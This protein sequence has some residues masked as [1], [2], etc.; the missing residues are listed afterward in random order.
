MIPSCHELF[1]V[2]CFEHQIKNTD[3]DF[4]K[5]L[6]REINDR[7]V[8]QKP[9]DSGSP[10]D[11][12]KI[13]GPKIGQVAEGLIDSFAKHNTTRDAQ[14][15]FI[16]ILSDASPLMSCFVKQQ[17]EAAKNAGRRVQHC[18][19]LYIDDDYRDMPIDVCVNNCMIFQG[20]H[21][22]ANGTVVD[23]ATLIRCVFCST[24]RWTHC[25]HAACKDKAYD[26]CNP[27]GPKQLHGNAMKTCGVP[28]GPRTTSHSILNRFSLNNVFYRSMT[29]RFT[30]MFTLSCTKE[31]KGFMSY[32]RERR[33]IPDKIIDIC[34]GAMNVKHYAEMKAKFKTFRKGFEK[35]NKKRVYQCSI[36][37]SI[38]YDGK[39]NFQRSN[40]SMWPVVISVL[41]CNPSDR[42]TI[43]QGL[44]L[45]LLHNI[46]INSNAETSVMQ[47][48]GE[49]MKALEEGFMFTI[50]GS[51]E[52]THTHVFLQ[53]RCV[54]AHLDTKGLE[55]F[56]MVQGSGSKHGCC[57]CNLCKGRYEYALKKMVY[58]N[59]RRI[60]SHNH[61]IRFLGES[62]F[63]SVVEE[64][65]YYSPNKVIAKRLHE[66][67]KKKVTAEVKLDTSVK[68]SDD[69][70]PLPNPVFRE[71]PV[72]ANGKQVKLDWYNNAFPYELFMACLRFAYIDRRPQLEYKHVAHPTY[73]RCGD[74]SERLR[75]AHE[76]Q[77]RAE[78]KPKPKK[79]KTFPCAGIHGV[80]GV[81][82]PGL[83]A[84]TYECLTFDEMHALMNACKYFFDAWKGERCVKDN[85]RQLSVVTKKHPEM[86]HKG[87]HYHQPFNAR[88]SEQ[89]VMDAVVNSLL[90]NT[91]YK[92][93]FGFK[94]P[95][96]LTGHLISHQKMVFLTVYAPYVLRFA[97]SMHPAYMHFAAR[98][99]SDVNR[100]FD[101]VVDIH[102][103]KTSIIQSIYETRCIQEGIF[104]VSEAVYI[105][106]ELLC[107][108]NHI[109][110]Y[111]HVRGLSTYF[112][113]RAIGSIGR[114]VNKGGMH[115][116]KTTNAK[117]TRKENAVNNMD[118]GN[119]DMFDNRGKYSDFV[120][121][122]LGVGKKTECEWHTNDISALFDNLV[123][124]L[125][126]QESESDCFRNSAVY[127]LYKAF[128]R[129]KSKF[130]F[131][132]NFHSWMKT[133]ARVLT[134]IKTLPE[135]SVATTDKTEFNK[136]LVDLIRA[137][138]I[139]LTSQ[140]M[141]AGK[142]HL[143]DF[144]Q[145]KDAIINFSPPLHY[146]AIVKG[147][148]LSARGEEYAESGEWYYG[149]ESN[150]SVVRN[151]LNKLKKFW[152]KP[153]QY[154]CFVRVSDW[155]T[156]ASAPKAT[157]ANI[158][159]IANKSSSAAVSAAA[160]AAMH[161]ERMDHAATE[162]S[163]SEN[164]LIQTAN[165]AKLELE[166]A[167]TNLTAARAHVNALKISKTN[168][169]AGAVFNDAK[170]AL[171]GA[172]SNLREKTVTV[173]TTASAV[174]DATIV[175]KESADAAVAALV[176]LKTAEKIVL[177]ANKVVQTA[178]AAANKAKKSNKKRSYYEED[179]DDTEECQQQ[180]VLRFNR[181]KECISVT[182]F[183][184]ANAFFRIKVGDPSIDGLAFANIT[185]RKAEISDKTYHHF[186]SAE[187]S[188]IYCKQKFVCLNYVDSSSIA[189]SALGGEENL[190]YPMGRP[191]MK[192][193]DSMRFSDHFV[194]PLSHDTKS[195]APKNAELTK[196]HLIELHPNRLKTSYATGVFND[197][198]GTRVFEVI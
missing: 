181:E 179:D 62:A 23:K 120:L 58:D 103:L 190:K 140:D 2:I 12:T 182:R 77:Q 43:G 147:I 167:R 149:A 89:N 101:P 134:H 171:N 107:I 40:D 13:G 122:L 198:D 109:E 146:K 70:R 4:V 14:N 75:T 68:D 3:T 96:H 145:V 5:R 110:M 56:A 163:A 165:A 78:D 184:Q 108:A 35:D 21:T 83:K 55:S 164:A 73:V 71:I 142:I 65:E 174:T 94:D 175:A 170:A 6:K 20:M 49:E 46:T 7:K 191:L 185:F 144:N 104:P 44:F 19:E 98:Y 82:R 137:D 66:A 15:E 64:Q 166:A 121:K 119:P 93:D 99:A 25:G 161:R 150:N 188:S 17:S 28:S 189:V 152:F 69:R 9:N 72:D 186:I 180:Q 168:F 158:A 172:K 29:S 176:A 141:E 24:P 106:H 100:L 187:D 156:R 45:A 91:A 54:F 92:S 50:P 177:A 59:N 159:A 22:L 112:S 102:E 53:A 155:F 10:F 135:N 194:N 16:S 87:S 128:H 105:F 124:F 160:N 132:H 88:L 84:F 60:L 157:P 32:H 33:K 115:Y 127:R 52:D 130:A 76:E 192:P 123:S 193:V 129:C 39:T 143:R 67:L 136:L 81:M 63:M 38:G 197:D 1:I 116:I 117:F 37:Y 169:S 183:G 47:L 153:K 151:D 79:P 139:R 18:L 125:E 154:G 26:L 74:E 111:G 34:D 173:A 11:A 41:N 196:L 148:Y 48:M 42:T 195:Y 80:C 126:T 114:S 178:T 97:A 27:C 36:C 118:K 85:I 90:I 57:F 8:K 95:F 138:D 113:E 31:R 61:L 86:A 133:V 51:S 162:A 30:E 131:F